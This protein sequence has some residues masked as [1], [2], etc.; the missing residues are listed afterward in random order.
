VKV[1]LVHNFHR[2]GG[3]S[4]D[5]VLASAE[6]LR[7]GGDDVRLFQRDSRNISD[8]VS[9]KVSAFA[10]GLY[11]PRSV[12]EFR[13]ELE[14]FAPDV[15]HVHELYPLISPWVLPVCRAAGVPVVMTCHDYRLTCPIATH[16]S[17]GRICTDCLEQSERKC[18]TNNCR[19]S[20]LE[21]AAYAARA[22]SARMWGLVRDTVS[23]Y[24]TPTQFAAQWLATHGAFPLERSQVVPYVIPVPD[25][26]VRTSAG[27]YIAFAGRFVP[28]KGVD[29]LL[30]ATRATG[31]PLHLAGHAG[32]DSRDSAPTDVTYRGYLDAV[33][34]SD[35]YRE[36]RMLVVPS[37]WFETFGIVAGQAM[38]HRLPVVASDI[39]ALAEVVEDGVTGLLFE[40]GNA[41]ELADRL[42]TLW[43]DPVRC[44]AMGEAGREKIARECSRE[45][46]YSG[47]IGA[48]GRAITL[49]LPA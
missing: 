48:Y 32:A 29:V 24:V 14:S 22:A 37:T 36:A 11:A 38:G 45:A 13:R 10:T 34:L 12:E 26:P 21:S 30:A 8:S 46:H 6:L 15:I 43:D 35:F 41:A 23:L 25:V 1:L 9:G 18:V 16:Y 3:G 28:E 47:L 27:R 49:G 44:L 42:T 4:D 40:T 33:A 17:H 31:L 5:A 7:E 19:S 2:Q 39:G 20:H